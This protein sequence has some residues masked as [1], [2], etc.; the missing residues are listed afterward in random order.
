MNYEPDYVLFLDF[1]EADLGDVDRADRRRADFWRAPP[2]RGVP[3]YWRRHFWRWPASPHRRLL[4]AP[5][6]SL[7]NQRA[8]R[9]QAGNVPISF[10]PW[11]MLV[12]A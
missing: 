2:N 4:A 1:L 10:S 9:K 11:L 7:C 12:Q 3:D 6:C 8:S 5:T